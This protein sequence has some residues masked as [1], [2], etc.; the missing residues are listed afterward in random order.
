MTMIKNI[1]LRT[2]KIRAQRRVSQFSV[3]EFYYYYTQHAVY[4]NFPDQKYRYGDNAVAQV[5]R[6]EKSEE[7]R[8]FYEFFINDSYI[9]FIPS[10]CVDG[11]KYR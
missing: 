3:L 2:R 10:R 1:M 6:K 8:R 11:R 4:T 9:L 5:V 7:Y